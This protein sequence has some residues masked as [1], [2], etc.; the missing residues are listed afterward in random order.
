MAETEFSLVRFKGD[1]Q[2]A[3]AVYKGIEPLR[4]ED[5]ANVIFYCTGLPDHVCI[6]D[7]VITPK[8]QANAFTNYRKTI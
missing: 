1:T 8:A 3:S 5:I 2:K 4:G 7:L 6:N